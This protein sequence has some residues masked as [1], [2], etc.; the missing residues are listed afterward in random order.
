MTHLRNLLSEKEK[1]LIKA[2]ESSLDKNM[3]RV[4]Q[5]ETLAESTL[6]EIMGIHRNIDS[7]LKK[8]ELVILQEYSVRDEE[9]AEMLEK[10]NVNKDTVLDFQENNPLRSV[11]LNLLDEE[12][13]RLSSEIYSLKLETVV[14]K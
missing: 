10:A 13:D 2:A 1:E 7:T 8:E 4:R 14:S 5:E 12:V 3:E 6:S 11:N 9:V